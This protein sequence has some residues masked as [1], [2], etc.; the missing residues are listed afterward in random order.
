[1]KN[2]IWNDKSVF[3][4]L[5]SSSHTEWEREKNDY[6]ATDPSAGRFLLE[7][8]KFNN[9]LEPACWEWHLSKVFEIAGIKV[10]SSD[11]VDRWYWWV[12]W[13][14]EYDY[15]WGDI[16]TNPPYKY[17]QEFVEHALS[18]TLP[19]A[20]I[21]MFLKLQFLEWKKRKKFFLQNPP[22][23]IYVSSSRIKCAMNGDFDLYPS[24]AVAYARYVWINWYF[25][26]P[27]VKRFN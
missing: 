14:A 11:I 19:W 13:F 21:A 16:V 1:M 20:K 4:T 12:K 18:I 26:D 25:G 8:E 10:T 7:L 2:R 27:V 24:S 9:V 17:A 15:W 22:K 23:I 3:K 5:W 6:Y